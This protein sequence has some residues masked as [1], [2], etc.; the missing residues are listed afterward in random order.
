MCMIKLKNEKKSERGSSHC[1]NKDQKKSK[2]KEHQ[3]T[4]KQMNSLNKYM[5]M[6]VLKR[7]NENQLS[8][9]ASKELQKDKRYLSMLKTTRRFNK[10]LKLKLQKTER[11]LARRNKKFLKVYR[12]SPTG[13]SLTQNTHD[14]KCFKRSRRKSMASKARLKRRRTT[15]NTSKRCTG[16]K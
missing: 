12:I 10:K 3:S 16:P 1:N 13:S 4:R 14:S 6:K 7:E 2:D 8:Y 15:R 5:N 9:E 11:P